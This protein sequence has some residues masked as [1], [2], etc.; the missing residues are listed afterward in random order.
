MTLKR[1]PLPQLEQAG[2]A[3]G[4]GM[5]WDDALNMWVPDTRIVVRS[6]VD[7]TNVTIDD[8]DPENPVVNA[9][10]GGG[11]GPS[12]TNLIDPVSLHATYGDDFTTSSLA[13]K[14]TRGGGFVS[15]DETHQDGG[16]S[17]MSTALRSA[18]S[19]YYQTAPAG[20]FTLVGKFI[21]D[22]PKSG[23]LAMMFGLI[24]V[25]ATGKGV[26]GGWYNSSPDSLLVGS[27][28]G[29]TAGLWDSTGNQTGP[30]PGGQ[31][32]GGGIPYWLRL[33]KT[34]TGYKISASTNGRFWSPYSATFTRSV[35]FTPARIG[36]GAF[37]PGSITTI[38]K[39][40][41]VDWFDVQ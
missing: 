4:D 12:S 18:G 33:N 21:T 28:G 40:I 39:A 24:I 2:A 27:I 13:G 22:T 25:D 32:L 26:G 37:F 35:A 31:Q 9:A 29:S 1:L 14:W 16:G 20:D 30:G 3:D 11:A 8:T 10:G 17:F 34:G 5:R 19:Y 41:H 38:A 7:G 6:L 36:F 15:G 23:V